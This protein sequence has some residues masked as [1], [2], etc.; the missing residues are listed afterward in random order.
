MAV[1]AAVLVWVVVIWRRNVSF[2]LQAASLLAATPLMSPYFLI[3]DLPMLAMALVFLMKADVDQG[4]PVANRRA[5]RIGLGVIVVLGYAFPFVLLP[6]GPFMCATVI[7][8]V[9]MKCRQPDL[10]PNPA[11]G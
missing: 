8:I 1:A 6:V 10:R 11:Y 4:S 3:Y 2:A 7:A 5:I 9:W